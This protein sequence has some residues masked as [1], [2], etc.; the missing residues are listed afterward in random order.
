[1]KC[2]EHGFL[3]V[4]GT[5]CGQELKKMRGGSI[6]HACLWHS[7][8][9]EERSRLALKGSIASRMKKALDPEGVTFSFDNEDA[10]IG[11]AQD[12]A[13]RAL[14]QDVDQ[15]RIK[16]G[17][18]AAKVALAGFNAKTTARMVKALETL[19]HGGAATVLL[20][21]MT[22]RLGTGTRRALPG[23]VL[24]DGAASLDAQEEK[25]S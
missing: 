14:T 7:R 12:M 25:A 21:Q 22:E 8:T 6:E 1:M 20:T 19:E 24:K 23:R 13:M 2:G 11:F 17:L 9:P 10:V 4:K 18:E 3:T 5:P 16:T 15:H